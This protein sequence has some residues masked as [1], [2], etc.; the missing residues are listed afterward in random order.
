MSFPFEFSN[1]NT[2]GLEP[3][4]PDVPPTQ[5]NTSQDTGTD[6]RHAQQS[7]LPNPDTGTHQNRQPSLNTSHRPGRRGNLSCQR[8]R[9]HKN[10]RNVRIKTEGELKVETVRNRS[11]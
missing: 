5:G 8:C 1:L 4:G 9:R 7:Y 3:S 6:A 10:G 11:K 2:F